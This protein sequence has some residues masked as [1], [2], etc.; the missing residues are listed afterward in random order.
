MTNPFI[1]TNSKDQILRSHTI[2]FYIILWCNSYLTPAALSTMRRS[3]YINDMLLC[4]VGCTSNSRRLWI[5]RNRSLTRGTTT[6]HK[7][8]FQK[9][10]EQRN[11]ELLYSTLIHLLRITCSQ[12]LPTNHNTHPYGHHL[13]EAPDHLHQLKDNSRWRV[14]QLLPQSPKPCKKITE[15]VVDDVAML[16]LMK[17]VGSLIWSRKCLL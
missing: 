16:V 2:L 17:N 1:H 15:A 5:Q 8:V 11:M 13:N 7:L 9:H 6:E 14:V 4:T 12:Q 10:A 3:G